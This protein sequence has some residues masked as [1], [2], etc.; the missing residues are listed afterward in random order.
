MGTGLLPR[1]GDGIPSGSLPRLVGCSARTCK[2]CHGQLGRTSAGYALSYAL[3]RILGPARRR[4]LGRTGLI[5]GRVRFGVVTWWTR[6][7]SA[8]VS[9]ADFL[10]GAVSAGAFG[11]ECKGV[12]LLALV[13][14]LV[15]V[16]VRHHRD[17]RRSS[18]TY[19]PSRPGRLLGWHTGF[20]W[21][22]PTRLLDVRV[23]VAGLAL[24]SP[25]VTANAEILWRRREHPAAAR[26]ATDPGAGIAA[27]TGHAPG[28]REEGNL[29][30]GRCSR[31]RSHSGSGGPSPDG[32][33][34]TRRGSRSGRGTE[35]GTAR[36]EAGPQVSRAA[37]IRERGTV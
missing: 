20:F 17:V 30:R 11:S 14:L 35:T 16:V 33:R 32:Q 23:G 19:A 9:R 2:I 24:R 7:R 21:D 13:V 15:L 27:V 4:V 3:G 12:G 31:L 10:M 36:P 37:A 18:M 22:D 1:W 34:V 29:D 28:V 8:A 6:G 25:I 5:S 26:P